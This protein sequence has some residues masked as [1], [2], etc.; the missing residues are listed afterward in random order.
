MMLILEP[1]P[2]TLSAACSPLLDLIRAN[3]DLGNDYIENDFMLPTTEE[4][5]N[6]RPLQTIL[7]EGVLIR[8]VLIAT[9]ICVGAKDDRAAS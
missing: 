5:R 8:A 1:T 7:P 2:P 3:E 4:I 6:A 9:S